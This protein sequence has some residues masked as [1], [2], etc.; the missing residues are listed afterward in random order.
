MKTD[1]MCVFSF[2]FVRRIVLVMVM[3][4][5]GMGVDGN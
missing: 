5:V 2:A 3:C 1:S 4:A